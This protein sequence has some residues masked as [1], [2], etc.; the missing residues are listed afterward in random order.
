MN[1]NFTE[2]DKAST[3]FQEVLL[4]TNAVENARKHQTDW[5]KLWQNRG[6]TEAKEKK[7]LKLGFKSTTRTSTKRRT[8]V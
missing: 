2:D 5:P 8:T 6:R 7:V 4:K 3:A 1:W